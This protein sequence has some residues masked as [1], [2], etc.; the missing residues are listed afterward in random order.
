MTGLPTVGGDSGVWG[1]ELNAYLNV[2]HNADGTTKTPVLADQ[3]LGADAST[4]TVSGLVL[5]NYLEV[6]MY[7][8]LKLNGT[9]SPHYGHTFM[10]LNGDSTLAHYGWSVKNS[11]GSTDNLVVMS[12]IATAYPTVGNSNSFLIGHAPTSD[13]V[14]TTIFGVHKVEFFFPGD[15]NNSKAVS[16]RNEVTTNL[17]NP[18]PDLNPIEMRGGGQWLGPAAITSITLLPE[19]NQFAAGSRVVIVGGSK[20]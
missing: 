11:D 17:A 16:F 12:D 15:T 14:G 19:I 3:T 8:N 6:T 18:G 13:A 2:A 1:T 10:Q 9:H 4:I 7:A 20:T 5:T